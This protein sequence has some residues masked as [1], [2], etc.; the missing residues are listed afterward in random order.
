MAAQDPGTN[1]MLSGPPDNPPH[2]LRRSV[3]TGRVICL[4]MLQ[5][6]L[7]QHK[8]VLVFRG[9]HITSHTVERKLFTRSYKEAKC[10]DVHNSVDWC[11]SPDSGGPDFNHN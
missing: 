3:T 6:L 4:G 9:C 1:A 11:H 7:G 8:F 10:S 2:F 5:Y